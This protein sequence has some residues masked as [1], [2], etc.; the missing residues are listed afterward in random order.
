MTSRM[1]NSSLMIG[2]K[3]NLHN[4]GR[5]N[6]ASLNLDILERSF[7]SIKG[8]HFFLLSNVTFFV[9]C[10]DPLSFGGAIGSLQIFFTDTWKR[11]L[12]YTVILAWPLL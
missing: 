3:I 7:S 12:R 9:D 1:I 11:K 6:Y 2:P 5:L 10:T 4:T 8:I